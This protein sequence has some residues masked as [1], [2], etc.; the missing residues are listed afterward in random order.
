MILKFHGEIQFGDACRV[1][2]SDEINGAI[3]IGGKDVIGEIADTEF[4]GK[5]TIAIADERFVGDLAVETGYGYSE[6]TPMESDTLKVGDHDIIKILER[7]KEGSV[8]TLWVADEPFNV[9]E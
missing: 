3:F 4:S 2:D 5:V 7:N 1:S 6:Y 8:I 9:L